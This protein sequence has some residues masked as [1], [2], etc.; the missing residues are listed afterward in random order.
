LIIYLLN[1]ILILIM[2]YVSKVLRMRYYTSENSTQAAA[3]SRSSSNCSTN[4]FAELL[5][6]ICFFSMWF[7]MTNR[8]MTVGADTNDYYNGFIRVQSLRWNRI[9]DFSVKNVLYN[10]ERGYVIF[11]K[12]FT[13]FST[14]YTAF[15]G[16]VSFVMLAPLY[17]V[18]R[19]YSPYPYL[20]VILFIT[21]GFFHF[22]MTGIRQG[23]AVSLT[24]IAYYTLDCKKYVKFILL[25]LLA[26]TIHT[27][28]IIFLS[29]IFLRKVK[30]NR[31]KILLFYGTALLVYIYRIPIYS[32]AIIIMD[33]GK[34]FASNTGAY[35]LYLVVLLAIT[36]AFFLYKQ[37]IKSSNQN[38][39]LIYT[40]CAISVLLMTFNTVSWW[41]LRLTLYY[42]I[43]MI[44]LI[45][46]VIKSIE[47]ERIR[48][49]AIV[50]VTAFILTYYFT[51]GYKYL[52][53]GDFK[54][55]WQVL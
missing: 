6:L 7:I 25:V 46:Y 49:V 52:N 47:N 45:P 13:M 26:S 16:L 48:F 40:L 53:T 32:Q 15:L 33:E 50:V 55:I 10:F 8:A 42:Y 2:A 18:I 54:F 22:D 11:S 34:K 35:T 3:F 17:F 1:V 12:A 41:A 9:I 38:L 30:I 28:S 21:L 24:F 43:Y 44:L 5:L 51:S 20:S 29:A 27:S 39:D 31:F 4:N 37:T 14:S 36:A 19:K 23:M